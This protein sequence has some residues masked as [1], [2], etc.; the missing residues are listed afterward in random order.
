MLGDY[1]VEVTLFD[2]AGHA[3]ASSSVVVTLAAT[4]GAQAIKVTGVLPP[5]GGAG[6]EV[7]ITGVGFDLDPVANAVHFGPLR[8]EVVDATETELRVL[9]PDGASTGPL[10]VRTPG[11]VTQHSELFVI[12]ARVSVAAESSVVAAGGLLPF[13][14]TVVSI[15]GD[16]LVEWRVNGVVGGA[17]ET[18][19]IDPDGLYHAPDA[20]PAGATVVVSAVV[21][22]LS[23]DATLTITPPPGG[24][25]QGL[26]VAVNGG[27]VESEDGSVTLDVPAGSIAAD[28][29]IGVTPIPSG[30]RPPP[31]DGRRTE[32]AV[33]FEPSG[34]VFDLPARVTITLDHAF[35]PGTSLVLREWLPLT[36]DFG[37]PSP[38]V[39]DDSG[40]RASA[41]VSHFSDFV[42][43][44]EQRPSGAPAPTLTG[45]APAELTEG[46][47]APVRITGTG[48]TPELRVTVLKAGQVTGDVSAT[49]LRTVGSEAGLTLDVHVLPGLGAGAVET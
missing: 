31:P 22:A 10:F 21:G 3:S 24:P 38:A 32:A 35:A 29:T 48:L 12:P 13:S 40:V 17:V 19:T 46:T 6:A 11:G 16:A 37:P 34:L 36:G 1:A 42:V 39:V 44:S 9:V 30:D 18:G 5:E 8:A 4:G 27:R 43:D 49:G 23:G 45:I 20:P 47:R 28:T 2:A 14:A 33:A 26:V 15:P 25:G 7:L 41:F